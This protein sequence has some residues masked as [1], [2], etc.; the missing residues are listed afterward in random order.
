MVD[1]HGLVVAINV[2][3]VIVTVLDHHGVVAI[4][5]VFLPD[6][7]A[8]AIPVVIAMAF[9]DRDADRPNAYAHFFCARRRGETNSGNGD[10]YHCKTLDHIGSLQVVNFIL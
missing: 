3:V 2:T 6:H 10:R 7:G 5:M 4:A 1:D 9:T 8:V